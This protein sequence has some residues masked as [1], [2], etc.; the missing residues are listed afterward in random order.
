MYPATVA[1]GAVAG[2]TGLA[3][4]GLNAGW[5][6]LVAV[7]LVAVGGLVLRLVPKHQR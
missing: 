4:T 2:T 5:M 7:T 1:T 3:F 6:A